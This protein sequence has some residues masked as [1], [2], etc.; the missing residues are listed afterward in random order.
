MYKSC[1]SK[2]LKKEKSSQSQIILIVNF[3]FD[4]TFLG[5]GKNCSR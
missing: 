4:Y 1:A 3:L 5:Y 2:K